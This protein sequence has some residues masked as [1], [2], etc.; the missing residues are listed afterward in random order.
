MFTFLLLACA[1]S[2]GRDSTADTADTADT[3]DDALPIPEDN[4]ANVLGDCEGQFR[5]PD[6]YPN[7]LTSGTE[8]QRYFL[9]DPLAVCN[10][11]SPAVMYVRPATEG[12]LAD[13]WSIHIQ[14]GG[15]CSS[16]LDCAARYCGTG[17]Y[18]ASKMSSRWAP[19][20]IGAVGVY[21][22][23]AG[24][25]LADANQV[26]IY[27]CSSDGW[28]GQGNTTLVDDAGQIAPYTMFH[29]GHDI[30]AAAF[31]ELRAGTVV[32]E[33]G[34]AM[35]DLD[36]GSVV[37]LSGTSA[38]SNGARAHADWARDQLAPNGT[39]VR[40]IFDAANDPDID[41][42]PESLRDEAYEVYA[43]LYANNASENDY[44]QFM[45]STCMDLH[46]G[47]ADEYLCSVD[48]Y[49]IRNHV[50]TPYFVRQDLRDTTGLAEAA[51]IPL[52]DYEALQ[53]AS[54]ASLRYAPD[55]SVETMDFTPGVYGPNC[56][57]HVALESTEW[58]RVA[59]V[60]HEDVDYTFQDAVRA[61]WQGNLTVLVDEAVAG[62]GDG[63]RSD[64]AAVDGER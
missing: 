61:W 45:D 8:M 62:D 58:W 22:S 47:T 41:A 9:E 43:T 39:D 35:P 55:H 63:P 51:E 59:T 32:G 25:I 2:N 34:W 64:C 29:H 50:T 1:T 31:A 56:A 18:D 5:E 36:D 23:E 38:G 12:A 48:S 49:V 46:G 27:Y 42:F 20:T 57:Q 26:F 19:P 14:G 52:D 6:E 21:D 54:L 28:S 30:V 7:Q 11:G 17:Y 60:S 3:G 13:V 33:G 37:L 16:A 53:E 24:N 44:V 4:I 15:G 40:A 10:D